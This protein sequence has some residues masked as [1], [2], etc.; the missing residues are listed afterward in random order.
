MPFQDRDAFRY[1]LLTDM[2]GC[3]CHKTSNRNG[4]AAAKR[5]AQTLR[6]LALH[7]RHR[8]GHGMHLL[9]SI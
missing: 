4:A 1:R 3:A 8:G 6:T 7:A 9:K 2:C 5:T